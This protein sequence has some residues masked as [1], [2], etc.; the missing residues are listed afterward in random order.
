MLHTDVVALQSVLEERRASKPRALIFY[1]AEVNEEELFSEQYGRARS[2]VSYYLLVVY[3]IGGVDVPYIAK[4]RYFVKLPAGAL[5]TDGASVTTA[6]RLA[7][8]R[9]TRA[10][11]ERGLYVT[12][13]QSEAWEWYALPRS[14][15][16]GRIEKLVVA[17]PPSDPR[18]TQYYM[19]YY[20]MTDR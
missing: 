2:R 9:L 14:A 18:G 16:T 13:N 4:V 19:T 6:T 7:V 17:T 15:M 20:H 3:N 8:C 1:R 10:R 12:D 5:N 11:M